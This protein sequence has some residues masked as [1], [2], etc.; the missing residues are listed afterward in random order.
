MQIFQYTGLLLKL[1]LMQTDSAAWLVHLYKNNY[2]PTPTDTPANYTECDFA[3]YA[4]Q[5]P[6]FG[7]PFIN[8]SNIGEMDMT[9]LVWTMGVP[10]TTNPTVY[11]YYITD[12][13]GDL[14]AAEL[15]TTGPFDMSVAG[16]TITLQDNF[17]ES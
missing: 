9:P 10:G 3:G 7:A 15:F 5:S 13:A 11:G 14:V 16:A 6:V 17:T 4:A 8:G 2:T 12:G 1:Q